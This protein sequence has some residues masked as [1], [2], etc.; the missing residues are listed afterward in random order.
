MRKEKIKSM[1]CSDTNPV[2]KWKIVMYSS[3]LATILINFILSV[4][5]QYFYN[6]LFSIARTTERQ[7]IL[8]GT[9]YFV[10]IFFHLL[11]LFGAKK[12]K[13]KILYSVLAYWILQL[14]WIILSKFPWLRVGNPLANFRRTDFADYLWALNT[15]YF[16]NPIKGNI[17]LLDSFGFVITRQERLHFYVALV[18]IILAVICIRKS[19]QVGWK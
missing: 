16:I 19:K 2:R 6:I 12:S 1:T 9:I 15:I 10:F 13:S 14:Y 7:N 4:N 8:F 17:D 3:I 18:F 5:D 11:I